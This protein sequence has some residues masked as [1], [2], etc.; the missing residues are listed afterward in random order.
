MKHSLTGS[1]GASEMV[2]SEEAENAM[3][4]RDAQERWVSSRVAFLNVMT[5]IVPDWAEVA[6]LPK[7]GGPD[8]DAVTQRTKDIKSRDNVPFNGGIPH[9]PWTWCP[10][11]SYET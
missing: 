8:P 7:P 5:E 10:T 3:T 6:T 1:T 9:H 11:R 2:F 4:N